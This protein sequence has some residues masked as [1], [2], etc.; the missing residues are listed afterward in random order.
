M[1]KKNNSTNSNTVSSVREVNDKKY[2]LATF[3]PEDE[4]MFLDRHAD[5]S[6][7]TEIKD[8]SDYLEMN[9]ELKDVF[10]NKFPEFSS[11]AEKAPQDFNER[12]A[13]ADSIAIN[14]P[15]SLYLSTDDIKNYLGNRYDRYNQV[16]A[17]LSKYMTGD[18]NTD[19][20]GPDA[21]AYGIRSALLKSN[22]KK[23]YSDDDVVL[24]FNYFVGDDGKVKKE[25]SDLFID[26]LNSFV[27]NKF[28]LFVEDATEATEAQNDSLPHLKRGLNKGAN[29]DVEVE[30][31]EIV[32]TKNSNG[33][34][35]VIHDFKYALPHEN[36]GK[37]Y[38]LSKDD[39]VFPANKRSELV[40]YINNK[41]WKGID[42][43]RSSLPKTIPSNKELEL[44][45]D[46]T[47]ETETKEQEQNK[48]T[49]PTPV[50]L[51]QENHI[52]G[53]LKDALIKTGQSYSEE[54]ADKIISS[55][56]N[57]Y[58]KIIDFAAKK[59]G[60]KDVESFRSKAY[61]V[62]QLP[63][64]SDEYKAQLNFLKTPAKTA[65]SG[66]GYD[67]LNSLREEMELTKALE[68]KLREENPEA[69]V[70]SR[71]EQMKSGIKD[72][73]EDYE[74]SPTEG[75]LVL[76]P[77]IKNEQEKLSLIQ[78]RAK[79]LND[80][81]EQIQKAIYDQE[82]LN[83]SELG[84]TSPEHEE[85]EKQLKITNKKLDEAIKKREK[86]ADLAYT[87]STVGG[88]NMPLYKSED[89]KKVND[90][91]NIKEMYSK[92]NHV[93]TSQKGDY[94]ADQ[95]QGFIHGFSNNAFTKDFAT[96]GLSEMGRLMN[97]KQAF[98][99][100]NDIKAEINIEGKSKEEVDQEIKEQMPEEESALLDTYKL[101]L[102]VQAGNEAN[103]GT[104]LGE[105][106]KD[107]IPFIV[108]FAATE[109]SGVA[110]KEAIKKFIASKTEKAI[111]GKVAGAI[112]KSTVQAGLMVPANLQGYAQRVA[113]QMGE[114]GELVEGMDPLEA[115]W[116]TALNTL[117]ETV[118]EDAG[119]L[120]NKFSNKQARAAYRRII[121]SNPTK[122]QKFLGKMGLALTADTKI[123]SVQGVPF[124]G[125]GEEVTGL[126][127][128]VINDDDSFFTSDAQKQIWALSLIASGG[129]SATSIPG[130]IKVRNSYNKANNLL[131]D[132][133]NAEYVESVRSLPKNFETE[134][135]V[136]DAL[137]Q[138]NEQ[139]EISNEDKL[140]A[141][142][143]LGNTIQYNAMSTA[144]S[145]QL[146]A[147]IAQNVGSDGNVTLTYI[148]GQPYSVRNSQDLG[149]PGK[150]IYVKDQQGN[151]KPVISSKITKWDTQSTGD[152]INSQM[153]MQD[154]SDDVVYQQE[155][156]QE[157]AANRGLSEGKTVNT[158]Y[159]K[160]TFVSINPDGTAT[161]VDNKGQQQQVNVDEI[162]PY[163]TQEQKYA[164]REEEKAKQ[165]QAKAEAEQPKVVSDEPLVEGSEYR[166][167]DNEDGSGKIVSPEGEVEFSND[168]ERNGLIS[169]ILNEQQEEQAPI[170]DDEDIDNLPPE[171]AYV[172]MLK[173][174]PENPEIAQE[175]FIEEINSLKN[176]AEENR[177]NVPEAKGRKAK[178][179]LLMEAKQLEI[180][181]QRLEQILNDPTL[182]EQQ[183]EV[184]TEE[185]VVSEPATVESHAQQLYDEY[186]QENEQS[187]YNQLEPWQQ[188][189]L[190]S[191]INKD[192]F[193]RWS[194][195][196]N[197]TYG[198][199]ARWFASKDSQTSDK[200]ID[201]IAEELTETAG[202]Q[203]SPEDIVSFMIEY[204]NNSVPKQTPRMKDIIKE[205][206]ELTGKS[207]NNHTPLIQESTEELRDIPDSPL[208]E[209]EDQIPF[210]TE[211]KSGINVSEGSKDKVANKTNAI[212]ALNQ[213]QEEFGI[214]VNIISVSELS[215]AA[216][217]KAKEV[218]V[219]D[220]YYQNGEVYFIA[221]QIARVSDM[222]KFYLHEAIVHKGLDLIF[223]NG[224]ITLL[225]KEYSSKEQLLNE[226][227][228]K[229]DEQSIKDRADIYAPGVPLD[230]LT[231]AQKLEIAEEALATLNETESPRLQVMLDKLYNLIKKLF[232]FTNKQFTKSDLRN[233]L[234]E[235]RELVKQSTGKTQSKQ[236]SDDKAMFRAVPVGNNKNLVVLH[237]LNAD[238]IMNID[239]MGGL[240]VPSLAIA[241]TDIPFTSYG[242]I[243]LIA[244]KSMVDPQGYGRA[245]TFNADIYSPRYPSVTYDLSRK[246][247]DEIF[248][249]ANEASRKYDLTPISIGSLDL[250]N[251]GI[252]GL[253]NSDISRLAFLQD[254]NKAPQPK[255]KKTD[256]APELHRFIKKG[257]QDSSILKKDPEFIKA[258]TDVF[259]QK[260]KALKEKGHRLQGRYIDGEEINPNALDNIAYVVANT[261]SV[262]SPDRYENIAAINDRINKSL[263]LKKEYDQ[264]IKDKWES[265]VQGEKIFKEY[266]PSGNRK[267]IPHT[268]DNVVKELTKGLQGEE[269]TFYGVGSVRS[270]AVK[271]FSSI[272]EIQKHRDD[273]ISNEDF[274][275]I[276]D[277]INE[278]FTDILELLKKYY[279]Y[280]TEGWG[281]AN[282]AGESLLE[283]AK[284][285]RSTDFKAFNKEDKKTITDFL[286][287]LKNMPSEYFES[288]VQRAVGLSEFKAAVVP[289]NTP[290]EVLDILEKNNVKIKKYN[291]KIEG[292][293]LKKVE[294]SAR[295]EDLKFRVAKSQQELEDFVKDSKVK[296]TVYHGTD[297]KL[298]EF[299]KA[300]IGN[301]T[302]N[303]GHYGY[304]FYFSTE[305][306]EAR[307]YGGNLMTVKLN[308]KN[309][310]TASPEQIEEWYK[311]GSELLPSKSDM[312]YTDESIIREL[313]KSD[314]IA[315]KLYELI[316]EYGYSKGWKI[317]TNTNNPDEAKVDLN[318]VGDVIDTEGKTPFLDEDLK[319]L[320][321]DIDKLDHLEGFEY[322]PPLHYLT[323]AGDYSK[324]IQLTKE[325]KDLGYDGVIYGTEIV[326]FEPDQILI[327]PTED[328]KFKVSVP[329]ALHGS[330]QVIDKFD[331][332]KAT[333]SS[334]TS[335]NKAGIFFT[336][337]PRFAKT[338][339]ENLNERELNFKNPL[340]A[341]N[342]NPEIKE[343]FG[344]DGFSGNIKS[345]TKKRADK[346][347][348]LGYD[349]VIG[350]ERWTNWDTNEREKSDVYMTFDTE[351]IVEP[352]NDA[353]TESSNKP[354]S[355][356]LD[357]D[358]AEYFVRFSDHINEDIKRG[359]SSWNFGQDGFEGD[360][361]DLKDY[362]DSATDENP[363]HISGFEIYPDDVKDYDF[364][365]LYPGYW[366]AK[367]N[368]NAEN[369]LSA[370]SLD[371]NFNDIKQ[372]IEEVK[373]K[374]GRYDG[375]GEGESFDVSDAK[376][377]YSD[378]DMHIV[379]VGENKIEGGDD[380]KFRV[381]EEREKVETNPS[382]AQIEAG[383]YKK[384]HVNIDGLD[385][386][387]ENP[388]GS[389]R[390]GVNQDGDKW[391][392]IMPAD[393]GYFKGTVGNDKDHIDVFMGDNL[394][395]DKVYVVD[396]VNEDGSFDEHKVM[397]GFNSISEARKAYNEAYYEGWQG[398]GAITRTTKE[399]LKE[400]F[401]GD[402][403]K[404]FSPDIEDVKFRVSST[405][406][407]IQ[408]M[409]DKLQ[410]I[411]DESK[412]QG[413]L[414]KLTDEAK[415]A[416]GIERDYIQ[417]QIKTFKEGALL[418]IQ[419]TKE[420][421]K[422]VQKS[423]TD[424]AKKILPLTESGAREI[425]PIL[426][427][428]SKAE[429]IEDAQSA[430]DRIE[431]LAGVTAD[432]IEKRK[433]VA[434]VN[435]LLK[436]MTGLKKSGNNKVG[437]F[438]YQ[439]TKDFLALK[440]LDKK[441]MTLVKK[442]NSYKS[443]AEEKMQAE[444]ELEAEWNKI[445][446][447]EEKTDLDNAMM[448]LIELRRLGSKAS[449]KLASMVA[450]E[451]ETIY[452]NAKDVKSEE[453]MNKALK[454]RNNIEMV[455]EFLEGSSFKDKNLIQKANRILNNKTADIMGNWE[456]ILTMIGG[457][458]LRDKL[459]FL[460]NE[461][462]ISVGKQEATNKIL[463]KAKDIYGSKS[464]VATL[465]NIHSLSE[466]KWTLKQP[467]RFGKPGK[468][469]DMAISKLHIMDIYNAIKNENISNDYFMS[470]GDIS[471]LPD[472]SRDYDAQAAS[473]AARI[474][475][476]IK[477]LSKEDIALAD[478]MQ[479]EVNSY[480]DKMNDIFIKLFNRDM[481]RVENYW[482]S[483]AERTKDIDPM[484][485]FSTDYRNASSMSERSNH[486]T[487]VPSDAFNKFNKH[488]EE[489]E[490]M[491][492]MALPWKEAQDIFKDNNVRS[493]LESSRGKD[494]PSLLDQILTNSTLN[495]PNKVAQKTGVDK[496]FNP[497]LNNWVASKIGATPTVV[498]K[499]LL[500]AVN[501]AENMPMEI[502]M[503][504]FIKIAGNPT[505]WA[506][507]W[508][509]MMDIP[510]LKTRFGSGYSE[511][512]QRALN[513]DEN[514]H[515]SKAANYHSAFKNLM[516]IGTRF[517]DMAAI[518][519]GGKPY[520]DYMIKENVKKG[521]SLEDAQ[522]DAVDKFLQDTL[523][524][525]QSPFS[526]SLSKF[527]NS[528]NLFARAFFAFANT[529]SQ[530][531]RKLFE[532]DQNLR[533][534]KEQLKAGKI[535]EE[536]YGTAKKQVAKAHSIYAL[537]NTVSFTAMGALMGSMM[538]GSDFDDDLLEDMVVQLEQT[539]IG[540]LPI[541]KD[542]I[543]S[544][545][546]KALGQKIYDDSKPLIEGI[547]DIVTAGIK[548]SN[549]TAK[550]PAKERANIAQ[551]LSTMLGVP[552]YNIK[553]DFK[554]LPPFR[555]ETV[556]TTRIKE[557]GEK[558]NKIEKGDDA[559]LSDSVKELK[560][561]YSKAKYQ[562]KKL[563]DE[564]KYYRAEMIEGV[565][566][567]SKVKLWDTKYEIGDLKNE[568]NMINNMLERIN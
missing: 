544:S 473:G 88:F 330:S 422:A 289:N 466:E 470:Y 402:T 365:E 504:D 316:K 278:E 160:K 151:V 434:K 288:K 228:S 197:I 356:K 426:T 455:E 307:H 510:Y 407:K 198:M 7:E 210:R 175:I 317:F 481:P 354:L 134:E 475:D 377:I 208:P 162:E 398:L 448:K 9:N 270:G 62:Y 314:P 94:I 235:H 253:K 145:V 255:N 479:D 242:D 429:T 79:D 86:N 456:T 548:L 471:L 46:P 153:T 231:E 462:Q 59:V 287:N 353:K 47:L 218:G 263:K 460:L 390:S 130:R 104:V 217:K 386:S 168:Q 318:L 383:N 499:Q 467:N 433:Q 412:V 464:K 221:E 106:L 417:H 362:L 78:S 259:E 188:Q 144:R 161:V 344:E 268:L 36:G 500:S 256:L 98:D 393:Y 56:D 358:N 379:E 454:K 65:Q 534:Q 492:N 169:E 16:K 113:P 110:A 506:S 102:N 424:Y 369:G 125:L 325:L 129:F 192:S 121:A 280:D 230:E 567:D 299:D 82:Q 207:I 486:R 154:Q 24:D 112:T 236:V 373:R 414:S 336:T 483:T 342:N 533:V 25:I 22:I 428:I 53:F 42:K 425:S 291:P 135:E 512:V 484:E 297:A 97:V 521:M 170:Q 396:Q 468:G 376:V 237:N 427:L 322:L 357:N 304:G 21:E 515:Q 163:Q 370:H 509:E 96:L 101:L 554:A 32:L 177:A 435:R 127:Q 560:K 179:Q 240:P 350:F 340:E 239:K 537:I 232:N 109:G 453:D 415:K 561:A 136:I 536:E 157:E 489:A 564:G 105:G 279:K 141:R 337:D 50:K 199:A 321:V 497:L 399:G 166:V 249:E 30:K 404:P 547:D 124:E 173:D 103:F 303:Y 213:M 351:S 551:G 385:I 332:D 116:K 28:P 441:T 482:P 495:A 167:I 568:S 158:P 149:K 507:T 75:K 490:W 529:P 315:S 311:S 99:T 348:E 180:E 476:L 410:E 355:Y 123:A 18:F 309:P 545:T 526:S 310:F 558:L 423:I 156:L 380:V 174:D 194:D 406:P 212:K 308:I 73:K 227:Y 401:K 164:I 262:V 195:K 273:I 306:K 498:A 246:K 95:L 33:S 565:I 395:S 5:D 92:M 269:G 485:Q 216:K 443:S 413:T 450:E 120:M 559:Q 148:D 539:Y 469:D 184:T 131:N 323:E 203:I 52:K 378:G 294:L 72:L 360:R 525:Q 366:V 298:D 405:D 371:G 513:G 272:E 511:A 411:K 295:Q 392:N 461:A 229:M 416:I 397:M 389:I 437:K 260:E 48:T 15:K 532:A 58:D 265:I 126:M 478:A 186:E 364:G 284:K 465:N 271:E 552:Y 341:G 34:Y 487:P 394:E 531:M 214:P 143:Y 152:I 502:W 247:F 100:Y 224:P 445:N 140:K 430:F 54:K 535:T 250:E 503:R 115:T 267:Y 491:V 29:K 518:A 421:I 226:V 384:G 488:I 176:K 222:K 275:P 31:N 375:T 90:L 89:R 77:G 541:I 155:Q 137:G 431:E 165:D 68:Q 457:N 444:N 81:I 463:D 339:G 527:Q 520:L 528:K 187:P 538:K 13:Y 387:I 516:T 451:L 494:F 566:E 381:E 107:M 243:S 189:L 196:S 333:G 261:S 132:I 514:T 496:M 257:Y 329:K 85:S 17:N 84:Y 205:Y 292:D 286:D 61:E 320:G 87:P 493:L 258:V 220:A 183:E 277:E 359:W 480:Y 251:A 400:W 403:K 409:L 447:K 146:E 505:K 452:N 293:R 326:A 204:P 4:A 282:G 555:D 150:I 20:T 57:D 281:Y 83:L 245:R 449:P 41:D 55:F 119:T 142:I 540:G 338:W 211:G 328:V 331:M 23:T 346:L 438:S 557:A 300:K 233:L 474:N 352:D 334:K 40:G 446:D 172:K 19:G 219:P 436:W 1:A 200:D 27:S 118:G 519:F 66:G 244:D 368:V 91:R 234:S 563:K 238:N 67:Y 543:K 420:M 285:G 11:I 442:S 347:K 63:E 139:F 419:D 191:R 283:Y 111:L 51:N 264:W 147:Q 10:K 201:A 254:I 60:I 3:T 523:R 45:V 74:W 93:M 313:Q 64:P 178:Q 108:Q 458:K 276:K 296:E 477:N 43:L 363:I 439:D 133:P 349:G 550:D 459:S 248:N 44:G 266:T 69:K 190:G 530:Y 252:K 391:S 501:Y 12:N 508:K 181:A 343:I 440:E 35:S 372:A 374:K 38:K 305:N 382:E 367:D 302:G 117:A 138:L 206:R 159:G 335:R 324:S 76:K 361:N 312:G 202:R 542:I 14:N 171:Q 215:E 472:G 546:Q 80:R 70:L 562:A 26:P 37:E 274:E 122:A 223:S 522:K 549:G 388:K 6:N 432:K 8:I 114:E 556:R 553:K 517:G 49:Q 185:D 408:A 345:I 39:I 418:G 241:R 2:K 209:A 182:L 128:A 290:K 327:E 193:V 71:E 301:A 225:G 319:S 524:S